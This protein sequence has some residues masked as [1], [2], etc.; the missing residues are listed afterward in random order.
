MRLVFNRLAQVQQHLSLLARI[1]GQFTRSARQG[2]DAAPA[3]GLRRGAAEHIFA[4]VEEQSG[5]LHQGALA[6]LRDGVQLRRSVSVS[7]GF[8]LAHLGHTH[9][10][11]APARTHRP[12][13]RVAGFKRLQIL[14]RFGGA[15]QQIL[16]IL[17]D[18]QRLCAVPGV[19]KKT[20]RVQ[21]SRHGLWF[22]PQA[23]VDHRQA[24]VGG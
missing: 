24:R 10:P 14:L 19:L 3:A 16:R 12:R 23:L 11:G 8:Q 13:Q 5:Q 18:L 15:R 7:G 1:K 2:I 22:A 21:I 9:R 4:L 17:D 20:G 6:R